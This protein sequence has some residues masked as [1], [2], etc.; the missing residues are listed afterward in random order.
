MT[1][2][3][4]PRRLAPARPLASNSALS[5][6]MRRF[7]GI[8]AVTLFAL[9]VV[10]AFLMPLAYMA[11]TAFKEKGQL[12]ASGSPWY[13]AA[14]D[15]YNWQ[16][17]DYPIYLVPTADGVARWALVEAHREDSV[18]VDTAHPEAGTIAWQG[19]WR[20]LQQA[21]RF[22]LHLQ[23]FADA[24]RIL[25]FARLLFNTIAIATIGLFGTL[26]SSVCVAYGF[27]RFRFRFRNGL[28]MLLLSTIVL[29][30]QVTLIPTFALYAQLGWVGTWLPLLVPHFFANAYNVFLLRQYFVTLPRDLDEAAM[31]D[32]AGPLRTLV[33]IIV[34]QSIPAL[35]AVGLFHFFFAWNDYLLPLIY[36]QGKPDLQPIAVGIA[37]F[38]ALYSVEPTLIQASAL[39][40][41]AMPVVIFFLA[42][43]TFMRGVVFTGVDK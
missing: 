19:R 28:F 22:E 26:I 11:T 18:F 9:L 41:I 37:N 43:R 3:D 36:L 7:T 42:Q 4:R 8:S 25:D 16:G 15:L 29:P 33:S 35:V 32:G 21:W 30:F 34:P 2:A 10:S 38:N 14:P 1:A 12:D 27:S 31:L 39:I 13:P 40:G 24:W 5:R 17:T 6:R 20:S 23:N